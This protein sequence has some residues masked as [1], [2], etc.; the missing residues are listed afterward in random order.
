[1][2]MTEQKARYKSLS[3]MT[4]CCSSILR[5]SSM[6][7]GE[8]KNIGELQHERPT[9]G[10]DSPLHCLILYCNYKP[11]CLSQSKVLNAGI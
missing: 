8:F 2:S 10:S 3:N 1:M 6:T 4:G 9:Q 7:K 5:A 11:L